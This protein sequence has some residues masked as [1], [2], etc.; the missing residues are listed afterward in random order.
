[1]NIIK[2]VIINECLEECGGVTPHRS[3]MEIVI[4]EIHFSVKANYS[5]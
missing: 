5:E 1:M 2:E 3:T 4:V